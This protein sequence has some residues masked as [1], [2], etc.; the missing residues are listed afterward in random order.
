MQF[1]VNI[2]PKKFVVDSK[3]AAI[4]KLSSR[5]TFTI[6][7]YTKSAYASKTHVYAATFEERRHKKDEKTGAKVRQ[8]HWVMHVYE[9]PIELLQLT[10]KRIIQ[11]TRTFVIVNQ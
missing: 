9:F 3:R 6:S 8:T 4:N 5:G 1:K 10:K 2:K 7:N 11:D